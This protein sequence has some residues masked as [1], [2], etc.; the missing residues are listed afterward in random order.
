MKKWQASAFVL[1]GG[2]S[3]GLVAPII[4]LA[5]LNGFSASDVTSSQYTTAFVLL[6]LF[7]VWRL[8][9]VRQLQK[10]V[11]LQM[12][13][14]GSLSAILSIGYY[15]SLTVLPASLAIVL[16]FQFTWMV[17]LIEYIWDR[18]KPT[19]QKW[20]AVIL[21]LIG[22]IFA[23]DVFGID[24]STLPLTGI[25]LGLIAGLGYA[26][27]LFVYGKVEVTQSVVLNTTVLAFFS[28]LIISFVFPPVFIINGS[29]QSG[30]WL[31]ALLIALFGQ[32]IPPISFNLGMPIVG[33]SLGAILGAIELPT[34]LLAAT[35]MLNESLGMLQWLGVMLIVGGIIIAERSNNKA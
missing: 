4:K 20:L 31:W 5:Y 25:I 8:K 33:P 23:V 35:W 2:V 30:L 26:L 34:T 11:V 18:V 22:T 14:L 17:I 13:A 24:I 32:I 1:L 27:F 15:L 21:I 12:A 7:S 16:L 10:K 28:A 6:V 3:Y 19:K 9:D 29:L